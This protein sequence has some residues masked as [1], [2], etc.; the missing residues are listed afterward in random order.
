MKFPSST[1]TFSF[2]DSEPPCKKSDS[3]DA[4]MLGGSPGCVHRPRGEAL[5]NSPCWVGPVCPPSPDDSY[6][7]QDT[8]RD[9]TS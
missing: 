4:T 9:S 7:S 8:F 2:G 1:T 5:V 3:I 6:V